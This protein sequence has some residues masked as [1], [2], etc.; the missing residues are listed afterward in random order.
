MSFSLGLEALTDFQ[1]S[2]NIVDVCSYEFLDSVMEYISASD[3]ALVIADGM[4]S[5]C[6]AYENLCAV[7]DVLEEHGNSPA[8]EALIGGNFREGFSLEAASSS[9]EGLW[10][11]FI[12][13][14]KTL[15]AKI[16][17]FFA[18]WFSS[19][20][21]M[22]TA[23]RKRIQEI[24]NAS[25]IEKVTIKLPEP[26]AIER[27]T[28]VAATK[29]K[30]G[31]K[32]ISANLKNMKNGE[33]NNA[34]LVQQIDDLSKT[35]DDMTKTLQNAFNTEAA[36]TVNVTKEKAIEYFNVLIGRLETYKEMKNEIDSITSDLEKASFD[37]TKDQTSA[38]KLFEADQAKRNKGK[39][40]ADQDHT[41]W[42]DLNKDNKSNFK[43]AAAD[44]AAKASDEYRTNLMKLNSKLTA[45]ITKQTR[46]ALRDAS[47]A[48]SA[49]KPKKK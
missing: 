47:Y 40:E 31:L 46:I 24:K 2:D 48:L 13:W 44:N 30:N 14:L 17:A 11:R 9:K 33:V 25:D 39:A 45:F 6:G 38:Q 23:M 16:K 3:E 42:S 26:T 19:S 28:D 4:E 49:F 35:D 21:S 10:A 7:C 1:D 29:M 15:W 37:V 36:S 41:K 12:K 27:V 8:L 34:D 20:D 43:G 5:L 18:K 32:K 22:I